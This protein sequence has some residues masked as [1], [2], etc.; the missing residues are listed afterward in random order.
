MAKNEEVKAS[1]KMKVAKSAGS[2]V[3]LKGI[4]L[5]D[6]KRFEVGEKVGGLKPDE[7]AALKEM[8]AIAEEGK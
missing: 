4:E 7:I 3:A 1:A 8:E 2:F 6:G 5:E